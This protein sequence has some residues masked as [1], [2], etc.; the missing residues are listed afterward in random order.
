MYVQRGPVIWYPSSHRKH[1]L[2]LASTSPCYH[3]MTRQWS[4]E[5]LWC[6]VC[7]AFS[8]L[9]T[10]PCWPSS[11]NYGGKFH[12][13][14]ISSCKV[15][16]CKNVFTYTGVSFMFITLH[17]TFH[18]T[19]RDPQVWCCIHCFRK[20]TSPVVHCKILM[21][22]SPPW[23]MVQRCFP[24]H[25]TKLIAVMFSKFKILYCVQAILLFFC[26]WGGR[27]TSWL[28]IL[29]LEGWWV[30]PKPP[31]MLKCPQDNEPPLHCPNIFIYHLPLTIYVR[32][33]KCI[34]IMYCT[35][36]KLEELH[37]HM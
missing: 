36:L 20:L 3:R 18:K 23:E 4:E 25:G 11:D 5:L 12:Q 7:W 8:V 10:A 35:S 32:K 33:D 2:E 34:D 22:I 30:D 17:I 19:P 13:L 9:Y 28:V 21:C 26:L 1:A 15:L 14:L 37:S 16:S 29:Q 24:S 27:V 31:Y 6:Q